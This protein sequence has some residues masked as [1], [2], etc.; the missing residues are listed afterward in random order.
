MKDIIRAAQYSNYQINKD[1]SILKKIN[2]AFNKSSSLTKYQIIKIEKILKKY[3]FKEEIDHTEPSQVALIIDKLMLKVQM[4]PV[5]L[6]IA[7]A[8]IESAWGESRFAKE[9]HAYFGIHC[10]E[11]GCGMK[12]GKDDQK[13]FVKTYPN[14]QSSVDGYMFFLNTKK[15]TN[16]F[17]KARQH[18]YST[19]DKDLIIL[20]ESLNSYSEIGGEYQKIINSLFKNYIPNE[21]ADY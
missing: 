17:R 6:A 14:L 10:Y 3:D 9:G 13:V 15:G 11:E 16:G 1:R 7:Q 4:V 21:I 5:R 12:F 18:Y 20:A 2:I 8:I 19:D